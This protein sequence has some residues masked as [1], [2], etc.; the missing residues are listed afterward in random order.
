MLNVVYESAQAAF[1]HVGILLT[2]VLLIVSLLN[3]LT[4]GSWVEK[5]EK[6][7]KIQPLFASA[8]AGTP[9]DGT[10]MMLVPLY[11]RGHLSF[12]SMIAT[13]LNTTG[14]S[15]FVVM[16]ASFPLF[17]I[18]FVTKFIIGTI[19]AYVIDAIGFGK[20]IW[21]ADYQAVM[22]KTPTHDEVDEA[23]HETELTR[24]ERFFGQN[25]RL[26]QEHIGHFEGDEFDV[27]LH[28][29]E[30]E[31]SIEKFALL[32]SVLYIIYWS[33]IACSLVLNIPV[34]N[35]SLGTQLGFDVAAIAPLFSVT[36]I[37][38]CVLYTV[39]AQKIWQDNNHEE[40]ES[41][42]L[43]LRELFIHNAEKAASLISKI[44][45]AY[46]FFNGLIAFIGEATI[47]QFFAQ[48]GVTSIFVA[49]LI[50][51]IPGCGPQVA[52]A[53]LTFGSGGL[54][55]ISALVANQVAQL[56]DSAFVGLSL[57]RRSTLVAGLLNAG[58]GLILGLLLYQL[59]I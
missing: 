47:A 11:A 12:G 33:L 9:G 3:Y 19:W 39:I 30:A 4:K 20:R 38:Y 49:V 40:E 37:S 17:V 24:S 42:M 45:L 57:V 28:H 56:G 55:P 7:K 26:S 53:T 27:I 35:L 51:L 21:Q 23:E 58:V 2:T 50:A 46:L 44:F 14:D 48:A 18:L 29:Q 52:F 5:I 36:A 8:L 54:I 6:T 15:A 31:S 22:K 32:H 1:M 16:A 59:G 34:L 10:T 13:Y 25:P 41:R 43:N